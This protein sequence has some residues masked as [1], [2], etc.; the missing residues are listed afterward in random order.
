MNKM[1]LKSLLAKDEF[2][3]AAMTILLIVVLSF[4][5]RIFWSANNMNSLQTSI[6]PNAIVAFGMMLL[7]ILGVF[8]LSVGSMMCMIGIFLSDLL[9]SGMS[10]GL[11]ILLALGIGALAGLVNGVLAGVIGINPLIATIGTQY[12]FQGIA[13]IRMSSIY[14][15]SPKLPQSFIHIGSGKFLGIYY[16]FLIMIALLIVITLVLKYTKAG[17]ILYFVGGNRSASVQMGISP[18]KI[19]LLTY[20][21]VGILCALAALLCVARY[22]NANRYLGSGVEMTAIIGCVLGGGT[23]AGG[24]GKIF[25]AL[26][27]VACMSL[28]R[29]LFNLF[30]IPSTGQNV[31]IGMILVAVVAVDGYLRMAKMKK[32]GKI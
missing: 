27:G 28:I 21:L 3:A 6:A 2:A 14:Q 32:L 11:S 4:G 22:E 29:N 9:S 8:D 12:I 24:K 15:E 18:Q 25:G 26:L 10:V 17:R 31:V 7:L 5:S 30:E 1:K 13:Y 19:I 23:F 16:Q 20:V